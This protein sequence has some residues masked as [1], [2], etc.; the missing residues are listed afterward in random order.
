MS[1]HGTAGNAAV[2]GAADVLIAPESATIPEG[3][4]AFSA[5]W[6]YA[7]ILDGDQGFQEAIEVNSTD[8][9]G[10]GF[11]VI[12]TTYQGTKVTKTFTALEENSNV[13][14]L[15]Y[16]TDGMTFDDV[17]GTYSGD[18]AVKDFTERIKIAFVTYSGDTE[19]RFISKNY[20]TVAPTNAGQDSETALGSRGFTATI[21]PDS[22]K[23][24]WYAVKGESSDSS[25]S[26]SSSS[27]A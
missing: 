9:N 1:G 8:H 13:M 22:S 2:W 14:G 21:V 5:D 7:G 26:S 16:D 20:A 27:S 4:A 15:V 24:L 11:G 12:A 23:N 3:L 17:A 25:S 6:K 18:L 10:W 19:R